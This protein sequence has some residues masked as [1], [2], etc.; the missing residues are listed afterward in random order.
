M[1][2]N[3]IFDSIFFRISRILLSSYLLCESLLESVTPP[4]TLLELLPVLSA[5]GPSLPLTWWQSLDLCVLSHGC[6][7][8]S[9]SLIE[10]KKHYIGSWKNPLEMFVRRNFPCNLYFCSAQA[11]DD[12]R[13]RL[14]CWPDAI[15][16]PVPVRWCCQFICQLLTLQYIMILI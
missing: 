2:L 13:L 16:C 15:T 9:M 8:P 3:S 5:G 6:N 4:Q 1:K 10:W 11:A 7:L 14:L 12:N